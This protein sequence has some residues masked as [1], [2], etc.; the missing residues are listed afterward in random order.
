MRNTIFSSILIAAASAPI[1]AQNLELDKIGGGLGGQLSCPLQGAPNEPYILLVDLIEFPTFVPQLG[2]QLDITTQFAW[3]SFNTPG[4]VGTM[5]GAG[6]ADPTVTMPADPTLQDCVFSF[7]AVAGTGPYRT[8]NL[9]RVT[10]Q[11]PGTFLPTLEAPPLPILGGGAVAADGGDLL[12]IGGTGPAAQRYSSRLETWES[13]GGTFGVGLLSQTTPLADGRV[14]F[15]GGLDITTGQPSAAAAIYDPATATTTT[16]TMN[17]ARA[18]HGASQLANGLVLISGGLEAFDL[19]NPLSIFQSILN[20]TELFDPN[21]NTFAPGAGMLEA[22]A[23]HTQTTLSTG[24]ALVAGG[25]SVLP[26]VN[27]PTVSATAYLYNPNTGTFGLP[28]LFSGGRLLHTAVPLDNG[29][30]LLCGG[31]S[32]D[33]SVVIQTGNIADLIVGTREDCLV[34]TPGFFGSFQTVNG[35]Q[36]GRAGAAVAPLPGGGALIAGGFQL[37]IDVTTGNFVAN[38]TDTADIFAQGP[39]TIT[40]TGSMAAP[41]LFPIAN[42][43]S[44][45]TIMIVGGGPLNAEVYQR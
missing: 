28:S 45:G 6:Q 34:Y 7:Q 19:T 2:V 25:L 41:R 12:F 29:R 39:N 4:F 21:S 32:V 27:L 9:V 11:L 10:P 40:P 42:N 15:T 8:S 20:T 36:V 38:A 31:L 33:L 13:A 14:L 5:D 3:S 26:I 43:L 22:R 30:V 16:L 44:D 35:M 37:E 17:Q 18:G 24:Q 1:A 23:L